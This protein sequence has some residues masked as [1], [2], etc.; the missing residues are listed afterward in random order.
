MAQIVTSMSKTNFNSLNSKK[1][2]KGCFFSRNNE[3]TFCCVLAKF[4][5][6]FQT[7]NNFEINISTLWK[8]RRYLVYV[9]GNSSKL[10]TSKNSLLLH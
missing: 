5:D 6:K 8:V 1:I 3:C 4:M 10:L 2:Y 9:I 7:E